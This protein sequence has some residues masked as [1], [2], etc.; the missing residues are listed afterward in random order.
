MEDY[1]PTGIKKR[2]IDNGFSNLR[3]IDKKLT[4]T[5][6]YLGIITVIGLAS[7]A[8]KFKAFKE[9]IGMKGE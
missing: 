2:Q 5:N 7:L 1:T 3:S 6:K 4:K 9:F 8:I